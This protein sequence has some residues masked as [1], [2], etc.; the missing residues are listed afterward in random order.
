MLASHLV[1]ART[2]GILPACPEAPVAGQPPSGTAA[3]KAGEINSSSSHGVEYNSTSGVLTLI[4]ARLVTTNS[5]SKALYL[6]NGATSGQAPLRLVH[7]ITIGSSGAAVDGI[8]G[9]LVGLY[10]QLLSNLAVNN[11]TCQIY[12]APTPDG[13]VT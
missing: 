9:G 3:I 11:V 12:A 8:V 2:S 10:G 7:C 5:S 4:R 6:T 13:N 1:T